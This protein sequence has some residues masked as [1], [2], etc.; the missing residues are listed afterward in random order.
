MWKGYFRIILSP[1]AGK[2]MPVL[3]LIWVSANAEILVK[4]D[5]FSLG[6]PSLQMEMLTFSVVEGNSFSC[7]GTLN[8][9]GKW[10]D[11]CKHSWVHNCCFLQV[12]HFHCSCL[13]SLW[14]AGKWA[15]PISCVSVKALPL[16]DFILLSLPLC[17]LHWVSVFVPRDSPYL[18]QVCVRCLDA[19]TKVVS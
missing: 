6:V 2:R 13:N 9:F 14:D 7:Y 11:F 5:Q 17:L 4:S 1:L 16:L 15:S 12:F 19:I 18:S 8:F 10:D 3:L